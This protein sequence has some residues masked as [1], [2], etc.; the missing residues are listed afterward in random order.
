ME[1]IGITGGIGSGKSTVSHYVESKGHKVIDADRIAH[2]IMEPNSPILQELAEAFGKDV[3]NENGSLHRR[4]LANRAFSSVESKEILERITHRE[5][6]NQIEEQLVRAEKDGLPLVFLDVVLLFQV[7]LHRLCTQVW[8]VDA[9]EELRLA[10]VMGR[11]GYVPEEIKKRMRSQMS[12][13][14]MKKL[15]THVL[16][17]SGTIL[18]LYQ[19]V[20]HLLE[21][22]QRDR[23]SSH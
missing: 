9:P 10:R 22:F 17:N 2:E 21:G 14:E 4:K 23:A 5:I 18:Q 1:I 20:D 6:L 13:V 11:D 15:A 8:V 12:P 16:E 3:L 19:Q 7:G